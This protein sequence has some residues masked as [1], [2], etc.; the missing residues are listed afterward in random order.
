MAVTSDIRTP[1]QIEA[2]IKRRREATLAFASPTIVFG[3]TRTPI[4][5]STT[6]SCSRLLMMSA[7]ICAGV[8]ASDTAL[9]PSSSVPMGP[10][11]PGETRTI[12]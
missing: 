8:L 1:A 4:S 3:C 9:P 5:S 2:D 12:P 7:S 10:R 11:V 6:A